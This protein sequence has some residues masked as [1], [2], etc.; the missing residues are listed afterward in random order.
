[1]HPELFRIGAFTAYTY[2][3]LV[4]T[5]VL[6]GLWYARRQAPRAGLDPDRIWN[7]GIYMVLAA[8]FLAKAWLVFGAW[9]YYSAHPR[10]IFS[11]TT[12]QSGGIFYG[13]V[14]GAILTIV[15]YTYFQKMPFLSVLDTFAA[16]LPL[17]HALGRLGCFAAGCCYGKPTSH[18]WGVTFRDPSAALLAGTPLGVR[19]HPTQLYEAGAE[20]SN[21]IFLVW[22]GNRQR[23]KGQ[24]LGAYFI[25]YGV[26]RGT[27]EFFRGDPGRTM[28]FHGSV[29]LMQVV[30]VGLLLIGTFLWWRGLHDAAA[31]LAAV[32]PR[33]GKN[34]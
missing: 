26:E 17:G 30:S 10:E 8:L 14:V 4:A 1:M 32:P 13:G 21:F 7:L 29:S 24:M 34:S 6:L 12:F 22:L 23:F 2:G 25:L 9:D 27:I 11:I 15:L 28:I 18:L 16:A 3:V 19:L 31:I 33:A 5:G 20:F